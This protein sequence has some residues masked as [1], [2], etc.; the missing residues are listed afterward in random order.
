[1]ASLTFAQASAINPHLKEKLSKEYPTYK[2]TAY[3][4]DPDLNG[5]GVTDDGK[6]VYSKRFNSAEEFEDHS[7]RHP[8]AQWFNNPALEDENTPL[9]KVEGELVEQLAKLE[10]AYKTLATENLALKKANSD[11]AT[12]NA[13]L[14]AEVDDLNKE[15]DKAEEELKKATKENVD[16][17]KALKKATA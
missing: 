11:G 17:T 7:D 3:D 9:P 14:N 15:L 10:A 8:D 1:M 2:F 12:E 6:Q 5:A 4:G 13:R 16:L